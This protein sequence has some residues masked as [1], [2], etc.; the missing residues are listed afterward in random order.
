MGLSF[1]VVAISVFAKNGDI[2]GPAAADKV[3]KPQN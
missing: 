2:P 1:T 3:G